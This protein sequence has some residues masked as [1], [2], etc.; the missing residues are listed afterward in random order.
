[1][2]ASEASELR[3]GGGAG[4][5]AV[6][7]VCNGFP[8]LKVKPVAGLGVVGWGG[9]AIARRQA[10]KERRKTIGFQVPVT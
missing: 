5:T 8:A 10:T 9:I 4:F 2:R 7:P 6:K 1:M 3:G